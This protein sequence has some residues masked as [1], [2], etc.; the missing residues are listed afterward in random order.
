M[1][2][3]IAEHRP[4]ALKAHRCGDC[5][6]VIASGTEYLRQT[7]VYDGRLYTHKEHPWC[8]SAYWMLHRDAGLCEDDLVDPDE[9]RELFL[10]LFV[11]MA[12]GGR[13]R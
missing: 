12:G 11:W 10:A 2:T 6:G 13:N 3:L 9:L 7:C 1:T 4:V 8:H 5:E